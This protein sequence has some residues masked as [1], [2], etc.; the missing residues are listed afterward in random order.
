MVL[1]Q[2]YIDLRNNVKLQS[3]SLGCTE[4][5]L[6][7]ENE[8]VEA[9]IGYSVDTDGKS[10]IT[11]EEGSWKENWLLIGYED[12]CGYPLFTDVLSKDYPVYTTIHGAGECSQITVSDTFEKFIQ[13]LS[14][15]SDATEGRENSSNLE[16]NPIPANSKHLDKLLLGYEHLKPVEICFAPLIVDS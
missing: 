4:I 7:N 1:P 6:F 15:I 13:L 16:N 9:Q 5:Y 8:L 12:C 10:L 11:N 14:Y 3:V 2:K